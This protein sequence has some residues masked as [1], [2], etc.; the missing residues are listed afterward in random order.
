M[1]WVLLKLVITYFG[2]VEIGFRGFWL[3]L[4]GKFQRDLFNNSIQ[5]RKQMLSKYIVKHMLGWSEA[6]VF[7][8]RCLFGRLVL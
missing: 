1:G 7:Q 5:L 3:E 2:N 4:L 8:G 6:E